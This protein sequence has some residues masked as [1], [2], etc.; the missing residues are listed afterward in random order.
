MNNGGPTPQAGRDTLLRSA[1]VQNNGGPTEQAGRDTLLR[2]AGVQNN[3]GP[4]EQAGRDTLL[5][6]AGVQNNG[7]PTEQAGRDTLLRSAGVQN[8][9]GPIEQAGRDTLLRSA[10][11]QNNG[12]PTEQAGRDTLLRGAGV[13]NNR[14]PTPQAGRDALLR[15]VNA[16]NNGGPTTQV[17]GDTLLRG[18]GTTVN[19]PALSFL[20]IKQ[21]FTCVCGLVLYIFQILSAVLNF[22][23]L[24]STSFS[25]LQLSS[26]CHFG[27]GVKSLVQEFNVLKSW[28]KAADQQH[29]DEDTT[30]V[31]R[32]GMS[33]PKLWQ[34]AQLLWPAGLLIL[35][36]IQISS[37]VINLAEL[38][39]FG[40]NWIHQISVLWQIATSLFDL[41]KKCSRLLH[42]TDLKTLPGCQFRKEEQIQKG[43][44]IVW[45]KPLSNK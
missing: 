15:G 39:S 23:R 33:Y 22:I 41:F 1:G 27:S 14:R 25:W 26:L 5:R 36:I 20:K 28:T 44:E 17:G 40:V 29:A 35:S 4:T 8:N 7:G 2:S 12:G 18:V 34:C 31:N 10:G 43:G 11:V 24:F 38:S 37:G 32:R 30:T 19:Q 42:C 13:Q 21:R 16:M 3:G 45:M 6:S 9:G